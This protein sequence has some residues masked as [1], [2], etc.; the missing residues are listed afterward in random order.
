MLNIKNKSVKTFL[1][2]LIPQKSQL[3]KSYKR[4]K[5]SRFYPHI[6]KLILI[7]KPYVPWNIR[8]HLRTISFYSQFIKKGD[9]CFDIGAYIGEYT[10]NFLR[11]RAKVVC[12]EP[13]L[14]CLRKL[15]NLFGNNKKVMIV[16]NAVGEKEGIS[17]ISICI[18]A[19]G[20]STLSDKWKTKGRFS[21]NYKWSKTQKIKLTTLD[22]LIH[23]YGLPKFCKI[24]VE[25]YEG[26]VLKGLTKKIPIICFEF[27]KEFINDAV[28]CMKQLKLT[29]DAKFNYAREGKYKFC[30]SEWTSPEKLYEIL[31]S[32]PNE[33]LWGDIYAILT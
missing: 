19:N 21:K 5:S 22:C 17:Q 25:G 3:R 2:N 12:V 8:D 1:R 32:N 16:G 31:D 9:L 15:Y 13:Q 30:L 14:N 29:G 7:F 10:L 18:N 6:Y 23:T 11:L 24:D 26:E 20:I 33:F 28:I 4:L 27:T